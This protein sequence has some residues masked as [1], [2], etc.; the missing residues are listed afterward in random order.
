MKK[1]QSRIE[2]ALAPLR[3]EK[4]TPSSSF[5]WTVVNGAYNFVM[6]DAGRNEY[7]DRKVSDYMEELATNVRGLAVPP[8]KVTRDQLEGEIVKM[9][10][11][12]MGEA[13]AYWG[14]TDEAATEKMMVAP[15]VI[16]TGWEK[17]TR[18]VASYLSKNLKWEQYGILPN[19]ENMAAVMSA[20]YEKMGDPSVAPK[21]PEQADQY[22]KYF[23]WEVWVCFGGN[24]DYSLDRLY[25][26]TIESVSDSQF[27]AE[28]TGFKSNL[29]DYAAWSTAAAL[30]IR[31]PVPGMES[32][33]ERYKIDVK[34]Q[35]EEWFAQQNDIQVWSR[36][37]RWGPMMFRWPEV[38]KESFDRRLADILVRSSD[39]NVLQKDLKEYK[40]FVIAE[41]YMV[42]EPLIMAGIT[43]ETDQIGV[44]I[45][46]SV[47]VEEYITK[48]YKL[49]YFDA[50]PR[51][52]NGYIAYI[53]RN[54]ADVLDTGYNPP[55][56][57][58]IPFIP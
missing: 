14:T 9:E 47:Y 15:N 6:G 29:K 39:V 43:P 55:D 16:G 22:A 12:A 38:Y 32:D 2:N 41:Q 21:T 23:I 45:P 40:N 25:N 36:V 33:L 27:D 24:K 34:K 5:S 26:E 37:Y 1:G 53:K 31:P 10:Y 44:T 49:K 11:K 8:A 18:M 19:P 46:W 51:D 7:T 28:V 52:L 4:P 54:M 35:M 30:E 20:W 50:T 17:S 13:V 48:D 42:Y 3:N 58:G 57:W 56:I